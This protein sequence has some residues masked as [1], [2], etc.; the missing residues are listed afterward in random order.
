MMTNPTNTKAIQRQKAIKEHYA[1]PL[2]MD[3]FE[4]ILKEIGS[5]NPKRILEIGTGY[6]LSTALFAEAFNEAT[7]YT[8]DRSK[9]RLENAQ[10]YFKSLNVSDRIHLFHEDAKVA[11]FPSEMDVVF[12]DASKSHHQTFLEKA[13]AVLNKNG[14]VFIDNM[15][16]SRITNEKTTRSRRALIKKHDA[17]LEW[18]ENKKD[19]TFKLIDIHDGLCVIRFK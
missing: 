15:H 12:I 3:V 8:Y 1:Y 4:V 7:L 6:G 16:I 17:F 2:D 13:L 19:I 18:L 5:I 11:L 10:D 9:E 14:V